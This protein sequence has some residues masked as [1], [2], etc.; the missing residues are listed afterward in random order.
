M[1]LAVHSPGPSTEQAALGLAHDQAEE[2]ALPDI[3]PPPFDDKPSWWVRSVHYVVSHDPHL[4]ED[5]EALY[6]FLL[7]Q[8]ATPPVFMIGC[9]GTHLVKRYD[10]YETV[11]DFCF[12]LQPPLIKELPPILVVGDMDPAYRGKMSREVD[13]PLVSGSP[14]LEMGHG[15]SGS[16]WR[17]KALKLE[18]KQADERTARL[19]GQGLPP[20]S[21]L[22]GEIP[23]TQTCIESEEGRHRFQFVGGGASS[24]VGLHVP[25]NSLRQWADDY[26]ASNKVF[27]E[28][29]FDKVV[30]GWDLT[31]LQKKIYDTAKANWNPGKKSYP[32]ITVWFETSRE[33][34]SVRPDHWLSRALSRRWI[35]LLL[36]IFLIYPLIIW[37]AKRLYGGEWRVAGSAYALAR[38]VHLEDSLPG[39]SVD[40]YRNRVG[41]SE[42]ASLKSTPRG[43]SMLVGP[44]EDVWF[45]K[46]ES[47]I[48]DWARREVSRKTGIIAPG[49]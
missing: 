42:A 7:E 1:S 4:N 49:P 31:H 19:K 41:S 23:G 6:R 14:D 9:K 21:L 35:K 20:W 16:Q 13:A 37:P 48:A 15:G 33:V 22:Q 28:F 47:T 36:C 3:P 17:R 39:E 43:V 8:A 10:T 32:N 11:T 25:S 24:D 34:V 46:W 38:W 5:G 44:T 2:A 45:N 29:D 12:Y 18:C 27:K 26:C 40:K 30:Y